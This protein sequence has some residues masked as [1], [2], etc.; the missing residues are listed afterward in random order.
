MK[1]YQQEKKMLTKE[2]RSQKRKGVNN[3]NNFSS[4]FPLLTPIIIVTLYDK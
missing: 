1:S 4:Y 2:K 3:E